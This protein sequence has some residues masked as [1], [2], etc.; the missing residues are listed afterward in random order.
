MSFTNREAVVAGLD[1]L[2]RGQQL[3]KVLRV[4]DASSLLVGE[5]L[6]HAVLSWAEAR[7]A[8]HSPPEHELWPA[9]IAGRWSLLAAVVANGG[10]YLVARRNPQAATALR[11]LVPREQI[12]LE[13]ALAG[14]SGKWTAVEMRLSESVVAR[15]LRSALRKLGVGD[16]AAL[17]GARTAAFE[18]FDVVDAGI[19]LAIAELAPA[20]PSLAHL[21]GA[22]RAIVTGILGGKRITA[23]AQER[24]TSPRTVAHQITSVY[25]K[26]GASSRRELLALFA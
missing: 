13:L 2:E 17:A 5:A 14:R 25:R 12:I 26:L 19:E 7:T 18:P 3:A 16:T 11:A 4:Q 6:Q 20:A 8:P 23:I 15:T 9:L 24:G 1:P 22:E 10:R 21:S